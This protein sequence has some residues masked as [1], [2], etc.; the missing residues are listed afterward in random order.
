MMINPVKGRIQVSDIIDRID[1]LEDELEV[2]D[3]ECADLSTDVRDQKIYDWNEENADEYYD[4]NEENADEYDELIDL[5]TA[6]SDSPTWK[7]NGVLIDA[8]YLVDD[9]KDGYDDYVS[10]VLKDVP[11]FIKDHISVDW[12]GITD[13]VIADGYFDVEFDGRTYLV[14]V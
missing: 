10:D 8:C 5:R 12:E 7:R 4:W 2:I 6:A 13:A 11:Y 1:E 9:I 3:E 14:E